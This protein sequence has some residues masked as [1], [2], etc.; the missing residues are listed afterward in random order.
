VA[1]KQPKNKEA[2]KVAKDVLL[3][4]AAKKIKAESG[5]Y[6]AFGDGQ[7]VVNKFDEKRADLQDYLKSKK[8]KPCFVCG[9]GA[10]FVARVYR[11]DNVPFDSFG[12]DSDFMEDTLA[13]VFGSK[14]LDLIET[15]FEQDAGFGDD[16]D[17][18]DEEAD[19]AANFGARYKSDNGRLK[20]ICNNIIANNGYF[21]PPTRRT[22]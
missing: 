10:C 13:G 3:L 6:F 18:S 22:V 14:Q 21:V 7:E 12:Y 2:I 8:A 5:T 20:A 17:I 15:A 4:L 9:V 16:W 19:A 11:K 1:T